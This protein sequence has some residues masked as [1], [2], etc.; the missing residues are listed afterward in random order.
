MPL[1]LA[2]LAVAALALAALITQVVLSVTAGGAR[3]LAN[4]FSYFTVLSNVLGTVMFVVTSVLALSG[5][6]TTGRS[7]TVVRC[8]ATI[9]LIITGV[10]FFALLRN[11]DVQIG[12]AW[13]NIVMHYV[14]PV[15]ALVDWLVTRR[16]RLQLRDVPWLL[17]YPIAYLVYS[18]IRG[19][20]VTWYPYPFIDLRTRSGGEVALAALAIGAAFAVVG[21]VLVL[22]P[23]RRSDS[24]ARTAHPRTSL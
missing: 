1:A 7:L 6:G 21:I 8:V 17:A 2:R 5:R 11:E 3:V 19:A 22:L 16:A 14:M 13:I 20:I 10:V 24:G 15:A 18:L 23:A 4:M 9:A 12:Q